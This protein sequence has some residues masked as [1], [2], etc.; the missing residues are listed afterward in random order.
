VFAF[1]LGDVGNDTIQLDWAYG[2]YR[3]SDEVGL[4]VGR[5]KL[6]LGLYG[7][8]LDLDLAFTSV[9]L[10]QSVYDARYRDLTGGINGAQIYGLLS[11]ADAGAIDYQA[12]VGTSNISTDGYVARQFSE[13]KNAFSNIDS[14]GVGTLS[15]LSITWRP[16]IPGIRYTISG[17]IANDVMA[18]GTITQPTG[19]AFPLPSAVDLP[20]T[21]EVAHYYMF[22][23]GIEYVS[24]KVTIA[25]EY[26]MQY[27][28]VDVTA[29]ASI[30]G[31][32]IIH[33]ESA[34]RTEGAY[35]MGDYRFD[36]RWVIGSYASLYLDDRN[37]RNGDRA[38]EAGETRSHAWQYDL[39]LSLRCDISDAWIMKIEGHVID[40]TALLSETDN[41][42]G[43]DER[44][45]LFAAKTTVSF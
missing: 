27:A 6:P 30:I 19:L 12:Y 32:G 2:D 45:Y 28:D 26:R 34:I 15:G 38:V 22:D 35:L 24:E 41:P 43:W 4:R 25:A 33:A 3:A 37:D 17:L 11:L 8:Y 9:L 5:C 7:E 1:D 16:P 14:I 20:V 23:T 10:P 39:A 40:G 29:D 44:W 18:E 36:E 42:N 13:G 21:S 31:G